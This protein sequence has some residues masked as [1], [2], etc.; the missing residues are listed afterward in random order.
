MQS[1]KEMSRLMILDQPK[2]TDKGYTLVE[3]LVTASIMSMISLIC[4]SLL[5]SAMNSFDSTTSQTYAD[6]DAV[7]AMQRIVADVREAKSFQILAN[8][9]RLRLIFPRTLLQGYYDRREADTGNQIDYYLSDS[10]GVPGHTGT[11]LWRGKNDNN[12]TR[13]GKNINN[14]L[15]EL[16]TT[17]SVRITVVSRHESA[18]GERTTSL[19]ERVV[20]LRNY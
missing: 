19:T 2:R 20:Y 17:R 12:R 11:Y 8:G 15:F 5:I 9:R 1:S 6:S 7:L 3:V 14:L 10:T 16:D 13:V 4:V 18:K